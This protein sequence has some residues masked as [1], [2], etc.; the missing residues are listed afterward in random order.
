MTL[1]RVALGRCVYNTRTLYSYIIM[2]MCCTCIHVYLCERACMYAKYM[3]MHTFS[4]GHTLDGYCDF[5][6]RWVGHLLAFNKRTIAMHGCECVRA[7]VHVYYRTIYGPSDLLIDVA[8]LCVCVCV[9]TCVVCRHY[10]TDALAGTV[11]GIWALGPA[12]SALHRAFWDSRTN[13]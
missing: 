8:V 7:C 9:R 11:V 10:L 2:Y 1:G 5:C 12:A 13:L 6:V 4:L 3:F